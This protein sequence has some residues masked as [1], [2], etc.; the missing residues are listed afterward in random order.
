MGIMNIFRGQFIDIIEWADENPSVLVHRFD[1]LNHEIKTGAKL[2]VRPGQMA[3]FVNEGKVAD[4]FEPGTYT[5]TTKNLPI[6]TTL[7]SLPYNFESCH[8]AEVYFIRTTEQLNRLWGTPTPVMMRD[9]DFNML[10][11][12]AHGNYSYRVGL[13]NDMITRFAG[14]RAEFRCEEIEKQMSLR[15]VSVLSDTLGELKIP[16]LDLA[17]NYVEI[18]D[19]MLK[20]MTPIMNGMGFELMSFTVGNISLP[21]N[22]NEEIDKRSGL[23]AF[24]GVMGQYTQKQAADAMRDMANNPGGGGNMMGMMFGA[25]MGQTMSALNNQTIQQ[26][27]QQPQAQ[28]AAVPP[29]I[30]AEPTY[31]LAVNGQRQG[32]FTI[33]AL[34]QEIL[35]GRCN[36]ETLV[37]TAGMANWQAAKTVAALASLLGQVPPPPP[38]P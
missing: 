37:W 23:G 29:P 11:L 16:A 30:P 9:P 15:L 6:L 38:L 25:Q 5:L 13:T 4:H 24:N 10:R 7:L 22:V 33:A 27:Q 3:V 8:K 28:A 26:P 21:D 20:R 2:I 18:G 12:R 34:Q 35:A 17:A 32:P 1:R 36:G 19:E 14:A 31:F